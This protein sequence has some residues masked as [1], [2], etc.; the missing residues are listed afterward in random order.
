MHE[1]RL[2]GTYRIEIIRKRT[3]TTFKENMKRTLSNPNLRNPQFPEFPELNQSVNP[4]HTTTPQ[5][6][7]DELYQQLADHLLKMDFESAM[8]I[9]GVSDIEQLTQLAN[10]N[11]ETLLMYAAI[12]GNF[13]LIKI[14][15][16]NVSNSDA[17]ASLK[18]ENGHTALM[19]ATYNK[20]VE[21]IKVLLHGVNN[22]D[23][24]ASLMNNYGEHALI[25][26]A[27]ENDYK[28]IE[29]ILSGANHPEELACLMDGEDQIALMYAV[30]FDHEESIKAILS[31]VSNAKQLAFMK[32]PDGY[33]ALMLLASIGSPKSIQTLLDYVKDP[34]ELIYSSSNK[35]T[36]PLMLCIENEVEDDDIYSN[37]ITAI[38][39]KVQRVLREKA[40]EIHNL[41]SRKFLIDEKKINTLRV[42]SIDSLIFLKDSEGMNA[43]MLAVKANNIVAALTLVIWTTDN[44]TL[45]TE[46]N[47]SQ[48]T[49]LDFVG[50]D[51]CD[52]LIENLEELKIS[53]DLHDLDDVLTTLEEHKARFH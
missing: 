29:A 37:A 44:I 40:N 23:A 43:F 38:L 21:S 12:A 17:L 49:A 52:L 16:S 13:E 20:H 30:S 14:L 3:V 22:P 24:L 7:T 28:I 19:H 25:S 27:M 18:D 31:S 41:G 6:L 48:Q 9:A 50:E 5:P 33:N 15:L 10:T 11:Q 46:K 34:I 26:A 1:I 53:M 47:N 8:R 51:M 39:E 42:P 2:I 36:T 35:G 32:N 4:H 45:F